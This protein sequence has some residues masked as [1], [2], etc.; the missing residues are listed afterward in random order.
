M[1]D[2]PTMYESVPICDECGLPI[3]VCDKIAPFRREIW[4]LNRKLRVAEARIAELEAQTHKCAECGS[5]D[6][7]VVPL[8]SGKG[9]G[10]LHSDEPNPEL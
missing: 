7:Y 5:T 2:W 4:G 3:P 6:T 9:A 10:R 8:E 1:S